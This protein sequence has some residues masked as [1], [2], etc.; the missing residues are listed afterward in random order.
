MV[1]FV[2]QKKQQPANHLVRLFSTGSDAP[3][4]P[5]KRLKFYSKS[6][7]KTI[8]NNFCSLFF[9]GYGSPGGLNEGYST[10]LGRMCVWRCRCYECVIY[11]SMSTI[12]WRSTFRNVL[13][14]LDCDG[15]VLN[16]KEISFQFK[17]RLRLIRGGFQLFG[18]FELFSSFFHPDAFKSKIVQHQI[19]QPRLQT[20]Q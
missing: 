17:N 20:E 16:Y 14:K 6:L 1:W 9:C 12:R 18:N 2:N 8:Q 15:I 5:L 3:T 10:R 4:F 11:C 19:I 7:F 13:C